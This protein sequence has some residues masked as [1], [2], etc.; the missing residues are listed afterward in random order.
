MTHRVGAGAGRQVALVE[1]QIQHG[2]YA[3]DAG[4]EIL[5]GRHPIGDASRFDLGLRAGDPPLQGGL[6][7]QEGAGDLGHGQTADHAQRQ[8][9][10]GLDPQRRVTAGEDQPEPV[11]GDGAGRLGGSSSYGPYVSEAERRAALPTWLHLFNHHRGHT[12]LG[13]RPPVTN[14][15]GQNSQ[16]FTGR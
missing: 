7:D 13:G 9:H 6:L 2:E 12:A 8:R 10:P 15:M 14:L 5:G 3:G 11:V 4:R 1:H 16:G